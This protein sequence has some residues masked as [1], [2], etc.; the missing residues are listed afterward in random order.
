MNRRWFPLKRFVFAGLLAFGLSVSAAAPFQIGMAGFSFWKTPFDKALE[1]MK[2]IDCHYFCI[3]DYFLPL[4]ADDAAI[5]AFR[6]KCKAARVETRASGPLYISDEATARK[7]FAQAKKM[8]IGTVVVVPF[9][10]APV[11]G[12]K[13]TENVES[14]KAL[15][16]LE[17]LVREYDIRAAIHN[18]GPDMPKLYPTAEAVMARVANRDR[19]I[20]CCLDIGH[21]QRAGYDPVAAIRKYGDRIYDVHLKNLHKADRSGGA[22]PGPRGVLDI[23]GVFQALADI[24]YTGVC[25]I[26]YERDFENNAMA[27]AE[28]FGYYRGVLAGLGL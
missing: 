4:D 16:M 3:K 22:V 14:E 21:E 7:L 15:D 11:D 26:E 13:K 25:H 18:H 10:R 8:G 17:K 19:R 12:Q 28:S 20:G 24:H 9:E 2:T 5:A 6:A 27:L 1:T 23:R